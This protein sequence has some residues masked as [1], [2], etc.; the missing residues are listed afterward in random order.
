MREVFVEKTYE[1]QSVL[2]SGATGFI[3]KV[4]VEKLLRDCK[5]LKNIYILLRSKKGDGLAKRFENFKNSIVFNNVRKMDASI[6]DKLIPVEGDLMEPKMGISE[7][8]EEHLAKNLNIIIHCAASVRFDEPIRVA[9]QL[10]TIST[11]NMLQLAEK[12][13]NLKAFVHVS[14]A[15]SNT[16]QKVIFEKIYDPF[17]DYKLFLD[18]FEKNDNDEL[19]ALCEKALE[20][21]PN[22]YVLTKHLSEKL[23]S[24]F[25][26]LPIT[27]VRP[28][29]VTP[30]NMEPEMGWVDSLNGPMGVLLGASSGILRTVHGNGDLTCD[31]IP[32]DF[33]A[34]CVITAGASIAS[35]PTKSL[36][37]YNCTS[38]Q[39]FHL[40]WNEFL[41]IGRNTYKQYPS[42]KVFWY[43]GGRMC[44]NYYFYF[45]YFTLFQF[46]PACLIDICAVLAGKK[47]WAIKLQRRI[48]DSMKVF[49]YF[50][51]NSWNWDAKNC[52]LLVQRLNVEER[53][54]F[55]FDVSKL[56]FDKYV[57]HWVIGSRRFVMKLDDS[58]IPEAK[59]KFVFLF[60]L[61]V[62]VKSIFA[63]GFGYLLLRMYAGISN[64]SVI[65]IS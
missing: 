55:N 63:M 15:Y 36:E 59:R 1:D 4:L 7:S 9:L 5:K 53:E 29:I 50:L 56:D 6:F 37:I 16:N 32:C 27:I 62:T 21:F 49:A 11:K 40:T 3:G 31:L 17:I 34:N 60:W 18:L 25:E 14:T 58:T 39:Q 33:V 28:S 46:I 42:T 38:S 44:A 47:R 65:K 51:N 20:I 23:V 30:S 48:F 8:D 64:K 19:E 24:D 2:V 57:E 61:D 22:T 35:S 41:D 52:Q 54:K 13:D 45:L 26:H 10:N 43:P 12:C